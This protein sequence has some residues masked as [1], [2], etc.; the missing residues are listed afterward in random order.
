M[1]GKKLEAELELFILD[2]HALSKDGIISK[3]EEI[4][5]KRKIYRSLRN[6]LKQEPEQCQALLYTGHILEN[7][8]R[9]VEDQK[10]EEDSLELTLKKWMCAIENAVH[11]KKGEMNMAEMRSVEERLA[12]LDQKMEQIK[13]QK[14]A[15]LQKEK[16]QQKQ[17]QIKRLFA[18]GAAVESVLG[19][20]IE[21][22]EIP[23]LIE[24]LEQKKKEIIWK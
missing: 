2:C 18:V 20:P 13:A 8:Y 9:F 21:R 6:L 15:I 23:K 1:V 17:A 16:A 3:S 22:E 12:E 19:R 11:D 7:A 4:V 24:F 5:M 10:E 14:K